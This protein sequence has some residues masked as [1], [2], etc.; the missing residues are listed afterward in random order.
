MHVLQNSLTKAPREFQP[1]RPTVYDVYRK[2]TEYRG[3]FNDPQNV[4]HYDKFGAPN[5]HV[6]KPYDKRP[7]MLR[8]LDFTPSTDEG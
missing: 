1:E 8:A 2:E 3:H 7:G 6:H 4:D 5:Y